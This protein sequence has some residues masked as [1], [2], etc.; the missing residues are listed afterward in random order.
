VCIVPQVVSQKLS[1]ARHN[2]QAH[3]C[4]VGKITLKG[5]RHKKHFHRTFRVVVKQNPKANGVFAA[6]TAVN[7]TV[8]WRFKH[9]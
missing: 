1:V 8:R 7:L 6:G 2:I 3:D 5:K 9:N 4:R